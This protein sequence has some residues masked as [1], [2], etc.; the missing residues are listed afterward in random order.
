V[1]ENSVLRGIF[2]SKREVVRGW[3]RLHNGK[4]HNLYTSLNII[5]VL[6][7]KRTWAVHVARMGEKRNLY[8][9]WSEDLKGR[10]HSEDN[11]SWEDNI[12]MYLRE[13]GWED[14]DWIH[15]AHDKDQWQALVS[16]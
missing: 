2:G 15:L 6:Q 5:K 16:I 7:S 13:T 10:D 3:R 8:K 14:V 9:F 12:R 1:S 11:R 4:L